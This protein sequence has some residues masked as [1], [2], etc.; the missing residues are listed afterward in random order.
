MFRTNGDKFSILQITHSF[1]CVTHI[2]AMQFQKWQQIL[3]FVL[4]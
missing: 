1:D 4:H 3:K 2:Y